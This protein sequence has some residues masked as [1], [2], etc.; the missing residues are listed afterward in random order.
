MEQLIHF[1]MFEKQICAKWHE[2]RKE[3]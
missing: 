1:I 2:K 3:K